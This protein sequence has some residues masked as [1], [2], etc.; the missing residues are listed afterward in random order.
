MQVNHP[1]WLWGA[2]ATLLT[3][4]ADR[5]V[6]LFELTNGAIASRYEQGEDAYPA[7]EALWDQALGAGYRIWATAA[8][9][10]HDI[11][12]AGRRFVVVRAK[13]NLPSIRSALERGD[14]YAS[15]GLI[16]DGVAARDGVLAARSSAPVRFTFITNGG[17]AVEE[18]EGVRA[19]CRV[20][21][22]PDSY[23]RLRAE[24]PDG[25]AWTQPITRGSGP[26]GPLGH[27]LWDAMLYGGGAGA[28]GG[29]GAWAYYRARRR[30]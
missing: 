18:I 7:L 29:A 30:E 4:L 1:T 8:D 9:D 27:W 11:S 21:D 25:K 13:R 19:A 20:P 12:K 24:S 16:L 22:G 14:F 15:T 17:R 23:L 2:T 5:G 6:R 3:Q 28:V 10:L 26:Y